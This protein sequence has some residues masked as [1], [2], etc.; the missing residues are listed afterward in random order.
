MAKIQINL[1]PEEIDQIIDEHV[2]REF[3]LRGEA[4]HFTRSV[5]QPSIRIDVIQ[6][7]HSQRGGIL[8]K[9]EVSAFRITSAD[10]GSES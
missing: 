7:E 6:G 4:L 5:E 10:L 1:S 8:T 2:R 9:E 3:N